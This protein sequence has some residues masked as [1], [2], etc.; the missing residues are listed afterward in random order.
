MDSIRKG[1][2]CLGQRVMNT[3]DSSMM[4]KT[5]VDSKSNGKKPGSTCDLRG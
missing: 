4:M 5:A 1:N 3:L 2:G